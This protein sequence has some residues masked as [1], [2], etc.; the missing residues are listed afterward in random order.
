MRR[1]EEVPSLL[2]FAALRPGVKLLIRKGWFTQRRQVTKKRKVVCE[3]AML[4]IFAASLCAAQTTAREYRRAHEREILGEFTQLLSIPNIASDREN[5]RRNAE[6]IREMMQR[7]GL[8]PQLL[9][10]KSPET[11]PAVYGEWKVPGAT[12]SVILYAHYD[13]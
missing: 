5:I 13:G 12:H 6:F 3:V 4:V 8:N 10:G 1:L 9:E 11:P 7:R 2:P